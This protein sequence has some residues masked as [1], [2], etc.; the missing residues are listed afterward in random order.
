MIVNK[1]L[2]MGMIKI[3]EFETEY[4][5]IGRNIAYYRRLK[6]MTQEQLASKLNISSGYLSK[7]ECGNYNKS[8]SLS[9]L[10]WIA[11]GLEVDIEK[12]LKR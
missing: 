2:M 7:I 5:I 6:G 8:I 9:M 12:L 11:K 10:F 3:F 1:V 4:R